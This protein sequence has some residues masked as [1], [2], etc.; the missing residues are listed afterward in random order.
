MIVSQLSI[1]HRMGV[2]MTDDSLDIAGSSTD[3]GEDDLSVSTE[4]VSTQEV[5][6]KQSEAE[7]ITNEGSETGEIGEI[8][9]IGENGEIGETG[10]TEQVSES[11]NSFSSDTKSSEE[12]QET[13]SASDIPFIADSSDD[14]VSYISAPSGYD[15]IA[16]ANIPNYTNALI[17][18]IFAVGSLLG[19]M[20]ARI[21]SWR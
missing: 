18:L 12:E 8:G 15:A 1:T 19:F 20:F 11:E 4:T 5:F 7:E 13:T 10:S 2:C 14:L 6:S 21:A 9:E 3:A 16:V 17:V